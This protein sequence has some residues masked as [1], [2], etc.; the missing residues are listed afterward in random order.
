MLWVGFWDVVGWFLGFFLVIY[1]L[2]V[3]LC[4]FRLSVYLKED[5]PANAMVVL[6][7]PV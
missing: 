5:V 1:G 3:V 6:C 2:A 4:V 7:C